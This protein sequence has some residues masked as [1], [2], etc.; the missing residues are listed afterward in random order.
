MPLKL[1]RRLGSDIWYVRGSVRGQSVFRTTGTREKEEEEA[2]RIS[3]ENDL[4]KESIHGKKAVI[5]FG[6][7]ATSYVK[8][9]GSP[10]FLV[11]LKADGTDRGLVSHFSKRKLTELGQSDLDAAAATLYPRANHETRNR[12][13]YTPFIAV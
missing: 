3:L 1:T 6:Q 11:K 5:T 13:V 2:I 10:R 8:S 7:A 4:L 9:G 12:Q